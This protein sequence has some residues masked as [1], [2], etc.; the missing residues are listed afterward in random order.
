MRKM[1]E[2]FPADV[3]ALVMLRS[4]ASVITHPL[5]GS[6]H[7]NLDWIQS[8]FFMAHHGMPGETLL[9]Q[10]WHHSLIQLFKYLLQLSLDYK[11]AGVKNRR[12]ISGLSD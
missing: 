12:H 11:A 6:K 9:F 7:R 5:L 4:V 10:I 8:G 1:Q 2:Q 3:W